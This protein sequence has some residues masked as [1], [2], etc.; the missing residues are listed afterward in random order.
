MVET[1][2]RRR[3]TGR[4]A[5]TERL[6]GVVDES[7]EGGIGTEAESLRAAVAAVEEDDGTVREEGSVHHTTAFGHRVH[8]PSRVGREGLDTSA[9]GVCRAGDV[10]VGSAATDDDIGC[11]VVGT[12]QWEK[13]TCSGVGVGPV[14]AREIWECLDGRICTDIKELC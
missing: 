9:A 12:G 3:R 14:V 1:R 7:F 10:L 6:G 2:D 8:F 13:D 4:E 11:P 5:P